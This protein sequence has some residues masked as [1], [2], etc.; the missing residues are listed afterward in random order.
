MVVKENA[1]KS[2]VMQYSVVRY[3]VVCR[4]DCSVV[5]YSVVGRVQCSVAYIS[6]VLKVLRHIAS[7]LLDGNLVN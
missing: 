4:V 5:I 6:P 7:P 3:G 2:S 1:K